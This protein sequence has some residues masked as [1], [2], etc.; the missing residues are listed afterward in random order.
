MIRLALL[1]LVPIA[2]VLHYALALSPIWVFVAGIAGVGILAD[3]I[4]D[5][6]E[7]LAG[8]TGPAI[9]G[10][11]TISLGSLAE[12]LL[13]LF[14][15]ARGEAEV[16]HAQITGS[17]IG[18]SLLGLGLAIVAGG[19]SRERQTFNRARAGQLSSMLVLIV[20][21]LLLPAVFDFT[22]RSVAHAG[23]VAARDEALSLAISVLLLLIYGGNLVYTL[24]THRDLFGRGEESE[25]A[26]ARPWPL[27]LCFV[28]LA[29]ATAA[30]ALESELIS[31]A[32]VAAAAS[33]HLSPVF[34]GVIVLALVGTIADLFSAVWF[35]RRDRM[36]L[37]M[38]ICIGSAIQIALVVTPLLVLLSWLIGSPM[39]L[40]FSNPL[41]LFAIAGAA[42]IVNVIAGDG[43]TT[44]FEGVLLIG[45]YLAL[46]IAFFFV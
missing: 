42:F 1:A 33:L 41:D 14:V 27:W 34:L 15:L 25:P 44:W 16:V 5:A 36:G 38:S 12:L 23:N 11:L 39:T 20:I 19:I 24:V 2:P 8:H 35:A 3:W 37:V 30:A 13:A 40:V 4:R 10:L 22:S 17:I 18:T 32:L 46:G 43:E 28:V 29:G 9:G 26:S 7:Q 31:A 45:V 6:T 21:A